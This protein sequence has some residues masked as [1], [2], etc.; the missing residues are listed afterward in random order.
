ML[1]PDFATPGHLCWAWS[2]GSLDLVAKMERNLILLLEHLSAHSRGIEI[3]K[4]IFRH[5]GTFKQ[6]AEAFAC[7]RYLTRLPSQYNFNAFRRY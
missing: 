4:G 7:F 6:K 2:A 3:E 5:I 1:D